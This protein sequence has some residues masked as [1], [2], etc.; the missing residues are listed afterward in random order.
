MTDLR[1]H[2]IAERII[3]PD[4]WRDGLPCGAESAEYMVSSG[5]GGVTWGANVRVSDVNSYWSANA[6]GSANQGDYQGITV[7]GL[8]VE[9]LR[10]RWKAAPGELDLELQAFFS[11]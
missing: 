6:C 7:E 8:D 3:T 4:D 5:D 2:I 9:P 10:Q 11:L 1:R